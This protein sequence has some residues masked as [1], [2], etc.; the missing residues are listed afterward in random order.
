MQLVAQC[1]ESLAVQYP[2]DFL[3]FIANLPLQPEPEIISSSSAQDVVLSHRLVRG[4][5]RRCPQGMWDEKLAQ[6]RRAGH[7]PRLDAGFGVDEVF[8]VGEADGSLEESTAQR[9]TARR[10][11]AVNEA[12]VGSC[13]RIKT[14]ASRVRGHSDSRA[15]LDPSSPSRSRAKEVP[16]GYCT[17]SRGSVHALR[18]PIENFAGYLSSASGARFSVLQLV[19][20]AVSTTSKYDVFGS[21]PMEILLEFKWRGFALRSFVKDL[22]VN[23]VHMVVA[24]TFNLAVSAEI[25]IDA[26]DALGLNG[27]RPYVFL[28]FG[29]CWTTVACFAF[30][31]IELKQLKAGGLAYFS[32]WANQLDLVYVFS[33][34]V[35]NVLFWLP[36]D[37]LFSTGEATL[38]APSPPP[39]APDGARRFLKAGGGAGEAS[40]ADLAMMTAG[41]TKIGVFATVQA[42]VVFVLFLRMLSFFRGFLAFGALVH[43]VKQIFVDMLPF[44]VLLFLVTAGFSCML[45]VLMQH[46]MFASDITPW[47]PWYSLFVSINMGLYATYDPMPMEKEW[48]V[49]LTFELFM[50]C[51]QIVLLNL[52][53]AIMANSHNRVHAVAQLVAHFERAKLVL[54]YEQTHGIGL[55]DSKRLAHVLE[56][57]GHAARWLHVLEPVERMDDGAERSVQLDT[58]AELE[59]LRLQLAAQAQGTAKLHEDVRASLEASERRGAALEASVEAIAAELTGVRPRP[60][61]LVPAR[62]PAAAPKARPKTEKAASDVA[63]G[64]LSGRFF[65]GLIGGGSQSSGALEA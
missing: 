63:S 46:S 4:S 44:M 54:D 37:S 33:H 58:Q 65:G 55:F 30:G 18:V 64:L 26:R 16:E 50:I 60:A 43:M 10:G 62:L 21:V 9:K 48:Q 8:G 20:D 3:H 47:T 49:V 31:W 25:G 28:L 35:V 23:V 41:S 7:D 39:L 2:L 36:Y 57:P 17:T 14:F 45:S 12:L 5:T 32:E 1:F 29:W 56:S 52:L 53:I 61:A 24:V 27:K 6:F 11:S 40:A 38:D 34:L 51:V 19:V 42:I 13:R 59:A 15:Q 22:L